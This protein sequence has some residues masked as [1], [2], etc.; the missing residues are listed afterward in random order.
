MDVTIVQVHIKLTREDIRFPFVVLR[1]ING[2][3]SPLPI[4][5]QYASATASIVEV[6]FVI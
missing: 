4:A 6:G 3:F 1:A 2:S 5:V